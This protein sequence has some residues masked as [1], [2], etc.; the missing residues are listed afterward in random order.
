MIM[1]AGR[2]EAGLAKTVKSRY[3][4]SIIFCLGRR[5]FISRSDTDRDRLPPG[6][7]RRGLRK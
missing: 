6:C 2:G 1:C 5:R 3:G 4:V 7:G